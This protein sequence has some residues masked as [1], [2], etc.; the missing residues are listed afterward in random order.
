MSKIPSRQT[1]AGIGNKPLY[2]PMDGDGNATVPGN[3]R[4]EGNTVS[5]GSTEIDGTL[6]ATSNATVS[7]TFQ[8]GADTT[9]Q[10]RLS[11]GLDVDAESVTSRSSI[12]AGTTI[13]ALTSVTAGT[14]MSAGTSMNIGT[15]LNI[16]ST[17]S[18]NGNCTVQAPGIFVGNGSGLTGIPPSTLPALPSFSVQSQLID[19][20]LIEPNRINPEDGPATPYVNIPIEMFGKPAGIY[21]WKTDANIQIQYL[22]NSASGFVYWNPD[23]A[24]KISGQSTWSLTEDAEGGPEFGFYS[25]TWSYLSLDPTTNTRFNIQIESTNGSVNPLQYANYYVN[26]YKIADLTGGGQPLPVPTGLAVSSI[27]STTA[28]ASWNVVPGNTYTIFLTVGSTTQAYSA[29]TSPVTL[30]EAPIPALFGDT[31]YSITIDAH[32]PTQTSAQSAP[33]LFTTLA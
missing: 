29:T 2:V 17:N 30:G 4:V 10:G 6:S 21:F 18:E 16:N 22:W 8:V 28:V 23:A 24:V 14:S 19:F 33:V 5:V 31:E 20:G 9:L 25:L 26:F 3:L 11:V 15:S 32:T 13:T 27:T 1:L 7:G 12:A